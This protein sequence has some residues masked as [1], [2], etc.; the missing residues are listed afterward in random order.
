MSNR[1]DVQR[2]IKIDGAMGT[3]LQFR[4]LIITETVDVS[5]LADKS[6]ATGVGIAHGIKAATLRGIKTIRGVHKVDSTHIV[7]AFRPEQARQNIVGAAATVGGGVVGF[8]KDTIA[9][10]NTIIDGVEGPRVR[11]VMIKDIIGA[12]D[13]AGNPVMIKTLNKK[14]I[15]GFVIMFKDEEGEEKDL[16]CI[17]ESSEEKSAWLSALTELKVVADDAGA[18]LLVFK[19][20]MDQRNQDIKAKISQRKQMRKNKVMREAGAIPSSPEENENE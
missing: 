14:A 7:N 12:S 4:N 5:A 17:A 19:K 15:N 9:M 10:A 2:D 3:S 8:A 18:D 6:F 16:V 11:Q 13:C 20:E 1:S